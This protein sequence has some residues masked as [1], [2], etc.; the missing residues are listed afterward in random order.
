MPCGA[1]A[2]SKSAGAT[3]IYRIDSP[4]LTAHIQSTMRMGEHESNSV[5]DVGFTEEAGAFMQRLEG[6]FRHSADRESGPLR[7]MYGER[8]GVQIA[9]QA[10][11]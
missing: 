2:R 4:P 9:D 11:R 8:N 7:I 5:L 1:T 3:E 6:R 10:A